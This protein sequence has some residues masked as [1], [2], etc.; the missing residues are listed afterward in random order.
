MLALSTSQFHKEVNNQSMQVLVKDFI[1]S[2]VLRIKDCK[3]VLLCYCACRCSLQHGGDC[4][5]GSPRVFS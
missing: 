5:L 2:V 1:S 3:T 4:C